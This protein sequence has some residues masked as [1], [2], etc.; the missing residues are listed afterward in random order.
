VARVATE[1]C[2]GKDERRR[3]NAVTAK[4]RVVGKPTP[5]KKGGS[6]KNFDQRSAD[7]NGKL[8]GGKKTGEK[9]EHRHRRRPQPEETRGGK[10][11]TNDKGEGRVRK[12]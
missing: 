4:K 5:P 10:E 1:V 2:L 8:A 3:A 6:T 7:E 12:Q 11:K 9:C